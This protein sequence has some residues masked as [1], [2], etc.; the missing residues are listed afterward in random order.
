MASRAGFA[1]CD[2]AGDRWCG[3]HRPPI[4]VCDYSALLLMQR[5]GVR[6]VLG[7]TAAAA[8][9]KAAELAEGG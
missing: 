9:E 1:S 2:R 6:I 7:A 8:R 4:G 3:R 5:K